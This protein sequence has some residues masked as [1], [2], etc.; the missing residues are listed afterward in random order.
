ML[1]IF[2]I[3]YNRPLELIYYSLYPYTSVLIEIFLKALFTSDGRL[4]PV[5]KGTIIVSDILAYLFIIYTCHLYI[6][7]HLILTML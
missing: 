7:P 2:T 4:S 3:L 1:S 5:N 6:F